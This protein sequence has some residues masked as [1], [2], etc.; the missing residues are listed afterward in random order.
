[1]K[2]E[3][4]NQAR[5]WANEIMTARNDVRDHDDSCALWAQAIVMDRF[6][7]F[8]LVYT[9]QPVEALLDTLP[10][11]QWRDPAKTYQDA[12]TA[13]VRAKKL[14]SWKRDGIR[15]YELNLN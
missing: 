11:Q 14:R 6:S 13:L 1:M 4:Q 8:D 7:C 2:T 15:Y 10:K 9:A 3:W 5:S 12:L